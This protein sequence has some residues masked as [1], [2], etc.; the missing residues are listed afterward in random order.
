MN[1]DEH[2]GPLSSGGIFATAAVRAARATWE[3]GSGGG[4]GSNVRTE[5]VVWIVLVVISVGQV[6]G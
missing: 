5:G 2:G 4:G 6:V 1:M 3:F